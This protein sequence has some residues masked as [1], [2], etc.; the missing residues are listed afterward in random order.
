[1]LIDP[2]ALRWRIPPK[3]ALHWVEYSN[4]LYLAE[5]ISAS[6]RDRTR[7]YFPAENP[8]LFHHFATTMPTREGFLAFARKFGLLGTSEIDVSEREHP[9]PLE[10]D[11]Q[12]AVINVEMRFD[13]LFKYTM[14]SKGMVWELFKNWE[15][16]L[17]EFQVAYAFWRA[18]RKD[19]EA[20]LRA[21][22]SLERIWSFDPAFWQR[23]GRF[24]IRHGALVGIA[25]WGMTVYCAYFSI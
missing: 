2:H 25:C 3:D 9:R 5:D 12:D 17:K 15:T 24:G 23:S 10:R 16:E 4:D 8:I 1:M 13:E 6:N 18:L 22:F 20:A 14:A 21:T 7:S 19:D 11:I